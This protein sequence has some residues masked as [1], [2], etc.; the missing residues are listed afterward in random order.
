M[1]NKTALTLIAPDV[2]S[3]RP[4][5]CRPQEVEAFSDEMEI[6]PELR[7]RFPGLG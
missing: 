7:Q 5:Q 2:A 1:K 6:F 3:R 4:I